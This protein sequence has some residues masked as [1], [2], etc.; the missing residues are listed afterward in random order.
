MTPTFDK[1]HL[2]FKLNGINYKYDELKEVV[3]S[4]V[5][6]GVPYEKISD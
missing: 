1:I 6:E 2:R 5:K 3:Y 4:L